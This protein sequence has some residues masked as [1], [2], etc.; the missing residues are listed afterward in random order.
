VNPPLTSVCIVSPLSSSIWNSI[1]IVFVNILFD[2]ELLWSAFWRSLAQATPQ[3][4]RPPGPPSAGWQIL[5]IPV[6]L[7]LAPS[8]YS[9]FTMLRLVFTL[10][11][12][13]SLVLSAALA[14]QCVEYDNKNPP[15]GVYWHEPEII[16]DQ[17]LST[18]TDDITDKIMGKPVWV[19]PKKTF[20]TFE[21]DCDRIK[22]YYITAASHSMGSASIKAELKSRLGLDQQWLFNFKD[23][24]NQT[25]KSYW[26]NTNDQCDFTSSWYLQD[27]LAMTVQARNYD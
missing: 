17:V 14:G 20:W 15:E 8:S 23:V 25:I 6:F 24:Y 12:I 19:E 22:K 4:A 10:F 3:S 2:L 21:C 1:R 13:A 7:S 26:L 27:L 5:S 9:P 18:A 16:L 11:A